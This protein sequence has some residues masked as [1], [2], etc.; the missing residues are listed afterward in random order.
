M[1]QRL[2]QAVLATVFAVFVALVLLEPL[3][4]VQV[5]RHGAFGCCVT[6]PRRR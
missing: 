3:I 6:R 5:R 2:L 4:A 1:D